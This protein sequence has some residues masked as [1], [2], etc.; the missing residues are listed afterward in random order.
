MLRDQRCWKVRSSLMNEIIRI[1][2][3]SDVKLAEQ[4][5]GSASSTVDKLPLSPAKRLLTQGHAA[6]KVQHASQEVLYGIFVCRFVVATTTSKDVLLWTL[7]GPV[8]IAGSLG[9]PVQTIAIKRFTTESNRWALVGGLSSLLDLQGSCICAS[10]CD[11][12][13]VVGQGLS[14]G[15]IS[16]QQRQ[17]KRPC[18]PLPVPSW[19]PP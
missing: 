3:L 9:T 6:W 15:V 11:K 16:L 17:L 1:T 5:C 13:K 4:Y 14:R 7:L 10:R 8:T 12:Q 19:A 2:H 18:S